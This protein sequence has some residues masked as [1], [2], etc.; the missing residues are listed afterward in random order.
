MLNSTLCSGE[1]FPCTMSIVWIITY[2]NDP[3]HP[4][5]LVKRTLYL[6]TGSDSMTSLYKAECPYVS[7]T[8]K[9]Y[10]I[11]RRNTLN[12]IG[13]QSYSSIVIHAFPVPGQTLYV[14][15][16]QVRITPYGYEF[17]TKPT[18]FIW[19]VSF[20][21]HKWQDIWDSECLG[22]SNIFCVI[23]TENSPQ[24][25]FVITFPYSLWPE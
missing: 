10:T 9:G 24:V 11:L 7:R 25:V 18:Y 20:D 14:Q 15:H 16:L 12:V 19:L 4:S 8:S 6:F 23:F 13:L 22:V 3:H 5:K 17:S 21:S 2:Q 1:H